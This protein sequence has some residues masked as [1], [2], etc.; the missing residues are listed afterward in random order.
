MSNDLPEA[1]IC[2][3]DGTL[4]LLN[5]RDPY[6]ATTCGND[7]VNTPIEEL[8]R[9]NANDGKVILLV[10]GRQ[11]TWREQ[12]E[13]WL[14]QHDIPY[15]ELWMRKAGDFRQDTII[16][17]EIYEAEIKDKYNVSFVLDDRLQVCRLW[18]SLGLMIL[19]VG[20]PDAD[21]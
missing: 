17:R 10:S 19:R 11:D 14:N 8:L 3:L 13:D 7:Q 2:D 6:D 5:S 1:V 4:A 16:K 20:D 21:F 15:D 18:Y 9:L 12:T